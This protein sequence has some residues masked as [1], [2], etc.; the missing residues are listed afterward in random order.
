MRWQLLGPW[1][2]GPL[3]IPGGAVIT[4]DG[5]PS[6][7][8]LS[9]VPTPLPTTVLALDTA[10]AEQM[11]HWYNEQD[12]INGW[13]SLHFH[14]SIDRQQVMATVR[15]Q[16]RWPNGEPPAQTASQPISERKDST[17]AEVPSQ[18]IETN[19]A[20]TKT[21]KAKATTRPRR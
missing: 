19:Q 10:S 20:Q 9:G 18:A 3:L 4:D 6:A 16:K 12:S 11:C 8:P 5:D 14:P 15:H 1:P 17:D 7:I 2:V 21:D 13:H